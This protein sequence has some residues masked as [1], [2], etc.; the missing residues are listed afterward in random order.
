MAPGQAPATGAKISRDLSP[1][2]FH[3]SPFTFHLSPFTFHLFNYIYPLWFFPS[4]Q[5]TKAR[6]TTLFPPG[7]G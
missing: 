1:F 4:I 3:L 5:F 7:V 6:L 2:T